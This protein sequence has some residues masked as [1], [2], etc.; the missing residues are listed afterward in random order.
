MKQIPMLIVAFAVLNLVG[1]IIGYVV[2]G[3]AIS[4][5]SSASAASLLLISAMMIQNHHPRGYQLALSLILALTLFFGYRYMLTH[6]IMP[7]AMMAMI[8]GSLF[9]YL[10]TKKLGVKKKEAL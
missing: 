8:S 6:K 7:S 5:V 2:A 3:S 1:G 4:L 10:T 9:C